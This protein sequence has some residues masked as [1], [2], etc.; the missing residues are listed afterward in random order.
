MVLSELGNEFVRVG[1][2]S[3]DAI[4]QRSACILLA[5]RST[6]LLLG[7]LPLLSP[8]T[9]DSWDVLARSF[10]ET[11][12]LLLTFRFNDNG[13]RNSI[14]TWFHG[15]NDGSWKARHKKAEDFVARL[16]AGDTELGKRW[17]AFSALSHPTVHAAKQS[18]SLV[19][20]W[21]TG[22]AEDYDEAMNPKF[23]DYLASI[24]SLIVATT[25]DCPEWIPL[26]CYMRRMPNVEPFRL[27][28]AQVADP[29]L[30]N[31]KAI[32]LPS[33]SYRSK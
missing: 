30:V 29:I 4:S 20:A 16:G 26:G 14:K 21:V 23:A 1:I 27:L 5:A 25:F 9:R 28:A 13:I 3:T 11:R 8:D 15:K 12:D 32:A 10:M 31:N 24:G 17:S 6:S 33:D 7:M 2:Q 18:T 19:V 22:R